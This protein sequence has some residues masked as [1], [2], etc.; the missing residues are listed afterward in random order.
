[1]SVE[2]EVRIRIEAELFGKKGSLSAV[3]RNLHGERIQRSSALHSRI[4]LKIAF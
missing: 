1:M 2:G 4:T 3:G